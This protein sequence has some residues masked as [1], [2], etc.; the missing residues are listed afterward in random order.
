M[1]TQAG[2]KP[3]VTPDEPEHLES[4]RDP[5]ERVVVNAEEL[6]EQSFDK[7]LADSFPT[8]DPPSSIPDPAAGDA[9]SEQLDREIEEELGRLP[10][11]TWAAIAVETRRL[12]GH[13]PTQEQAIEEAKRRGHS[14]LRLVQVEG[15]AEAG[16]G[17]TQRA[18]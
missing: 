5:E 13:G 8:S 12:V 9:P 16:E 1:T 18:S 11:G 4:R 14:Q 17:I 15:E 2:G 3:Q 7:T 6:K 10:A